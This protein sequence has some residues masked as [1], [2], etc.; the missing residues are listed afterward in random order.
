MK[1][2]LY[3]VLVGSVLVSGSLLLKSL[4]IVSGSSLDGIGTARTCTLMAGNTFDAGKEL[5]VRVP[6]H[7]TQTLEY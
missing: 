6:L 4:S 3:S 5:I 2:A 1:F 7:Q